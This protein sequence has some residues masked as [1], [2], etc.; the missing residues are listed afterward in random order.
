M[1]TVWTELQEIA[2]HQDRLETQDLME[3]RVTKEKLDMEPQEPREHAVHQDQL[4][5][6]DLKDQL[7]LLDKRETHMLSQSKERQEPVE[8]QGVMG[9][10]ER[11]VL[12]DR[13]DPQEC[14]EP[15]EIV[16]PQDADLWEPKESVG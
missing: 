12:T 4:D 10:Q 16:E 7:D 1:P 15:R 11:T 3:P 6:L 2:E 5:P 8:L 13:Q 14:Q 9:H